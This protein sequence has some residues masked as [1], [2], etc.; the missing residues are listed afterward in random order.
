MWMPNAAICARPAMSRA[1]T[2]S[3][4]LRSFDTRARTLWSMTA[5]FMSTTAHTAKQENA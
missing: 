3:G 2:I 4:T 1:A 5:R